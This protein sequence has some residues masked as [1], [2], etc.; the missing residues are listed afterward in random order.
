MSK[1]HRT[2]EAV[3]TCTWNVE[4]GEELCTA[5]RVSGR[6]VEIAETESIVQKQKRVSE[7]SEYSRSLV[8]FGERLT[9][10]LT[11]LYGMSTT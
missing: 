4:S 9:R 7:E 2:L 5:K 11:L 3:D 6:S 1:S 8:A 10:T